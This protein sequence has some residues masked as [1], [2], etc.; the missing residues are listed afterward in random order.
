[1]LDNDE[2]F[3]IREEVKLEHLDED[4]EKND[5]DQ[6]KVVEHI[7]T[8]K[9]LLQKQHLDR[10][11]CI[12]KDKLS[13]DFNSYKVSFNQITKKLTSCYERID[14][15]R[16]HIDISIK[17]KSLTDIE[18]HNN[19][20]DTERQNLRSIINELNSI[21]ITSTTVTADCLSKILY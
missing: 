12:T 6:K 20:L 11:K 2:E 3:D 10:E 17:K 8:Q 7:K 5:Q 16:T 1:M 14:D 15:L 13:K 19:E 4:E 21:Y 9:E 18:K